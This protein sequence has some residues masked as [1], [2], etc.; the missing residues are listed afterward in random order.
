[1]KVIERDVEEAQL[2]PAAP[3]Q[4]AG[5]VPG[6]RSNSGNSSQSDAAGAVSATARLGCGAPARGGAVGASL[7]PEYIVDLLKALLMELCETT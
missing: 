3:G 2:E 7:G 5:L 6:L 4:G 1:M